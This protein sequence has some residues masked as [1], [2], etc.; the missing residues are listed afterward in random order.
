MFSQNN[1]TGMTTKKLLYELETELDETIKSIEK[2]GGFYIG[3][4]IGISCFK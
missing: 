1:L 3:R 4:Y 2:Y